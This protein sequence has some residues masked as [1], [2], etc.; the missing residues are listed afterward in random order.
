[1]IKIVYTCNDN[2]LDGLYLSILSILRRSKET[3]QFYLLTGDCTDIKPYYTKFSKKSAKIIDDLVKSFNKDNSFKVFDC[4]EL[5]KK[6]IP[7]N[8][9]NKCKYSPY[10][11]FRLLMD[12][13]DEINGKIL[14]LD[15]DTMANNDIKELYDIDLK[16]NEFAASHDCMGRFWIKR[17]YFN[18]GVMLFNIDTIRK[19]KLFEK[20]RKLL[21]ERK[22]YFSDQSALY[23]CKTKSMFFPDEYRFNRQQSYVKPNDVIK[24]FA[25][26]VKGWPKHHNI[27]QWQIDDVHK[28]LKI[29]AFDEDFKIYLEAKKGW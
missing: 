9:N 17:D 18:S 12:E 11:M 19:T 3:F 10:A 26:R 24:H 22:L 28:R 20:A 14:Y 21:S 1:M 15:V 27:K 16:D 8:K 23:L 25:A 2:Y 4:T 6:L 5:Y 7:A 13:I 29:F